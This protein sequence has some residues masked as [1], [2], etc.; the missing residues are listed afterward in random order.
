MI[1]GETL[2]ENGKE[3]HLDELVDRRMPI[4]REEFPR[5]ANA[6][7]ADV[8][9]WVLRFG[10]DF[11]EVKLPTLFV[12]V[13]DVVRLRRAL[14]DDEIA[15]EL[16]LLIAFVLKA[17]GSNPVRWA[18]LRCRLLFATKRCIGCVDAVARRDP[19]R[20]VCTTESDCCCFSLRTNPFLERGSQRFSV[21]FDIIDG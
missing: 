14:F 7:E 4:D 16:D 9:V 19:C 18:W 21:T 1:D 2:H 8:H 17:A 11:V 6:F 15:F 12:I 13:V 3:V 5:G 10:D 20:D